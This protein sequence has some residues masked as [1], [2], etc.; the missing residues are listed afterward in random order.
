[1]QLGAHNTMGPQLTSLLT[2]S[3]FSTRNQTE[4]IGSEL[5]QLSPLTG[6]G[7]D[8]S[9][10]ITYRLETVESWPFVIRD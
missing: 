1:M 10:H 9:Q 7:I 3:R 6:A 5:A 8:F 2:D 4:R